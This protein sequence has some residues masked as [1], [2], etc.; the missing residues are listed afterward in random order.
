MVTT[1]CFHPVTR[2]G[3]GQSYETSC[4]TLTIWHLY[5]IN[6]L[7]KKEFHLL[8]W[9][10]NSIMHYYAST[11]VFGKIKAITVYWNRGR[12]ISTCKWTAA[13]LRD[14][15]I[16]AAAKTPSRSIV[17]RN[18]KEK[19]NIGAFNCHK[20]KKVSEKFNRMIFRLVRRCCTDITD[21]SCI[22]YSLIWG[23]FR[24]M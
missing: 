2:I 23:D 15:G 1:N 4:E 20:M 10:I 5:T 12:N 8:L 17:A 24:I 21:H 19:K 22:F 13:S 14:Y 16:R 9:N 6:I 11:S 18:A 3:Y 7:F